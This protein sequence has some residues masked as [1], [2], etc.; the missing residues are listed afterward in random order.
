[1]SLNP[2]TAGARGIQESDWVEIRTP[3]ATVRMRAK[4]DAALHPRVVSAQY[5]WWQENEALGLAGFDAFADTGS[6]YNRLIADDITDPIS[7]STGL[8]SALCDIRKIEL[9]DNQPTRGAVEG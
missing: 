8:R 5:G 4:F 6:N 3:K 2:E 9:L 7:G 1:V